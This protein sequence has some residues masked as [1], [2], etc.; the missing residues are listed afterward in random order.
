MHRAEA[1]VNVSNKWGTGYVRYLTDDF[2]VDLTNPADPSSQKRE[3]L[4][5]GGELYFGRTGGVSAYG[6]RDNRP[7]RLGD[8]RHRVFYRDDCTRVDV[9]YRREDTRDRTA[10]TQLV[11]QRTPN[12]RH[13]GRT[14]LW[15]IGMPA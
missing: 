1:G 15:Q 11:G 10:G 5:L 3:N 6:N 12:A 8:P 9:I 14:T 4:D 13:I 2:D 7:E